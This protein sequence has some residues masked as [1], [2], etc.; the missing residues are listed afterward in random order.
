MIDYKNDYCIKILVKQWDLKFFRLFFKTV[1]LEN[2]T[3]C[4]VLGIL[5]LRRH[6]AFQVQIFLYCYSPEK[7][8]VGLLIFPSL[9][10]WHVTDM[11]E[12]ALR[13]TSF[14][15][16]ERWF[17]VYLFLLLSKEYLSSFFLFLHIFSKFPFLAIMKGS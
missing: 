10:A 17:F 7:N 13:G 12:I 1:K 11:E 6:S 5:D 3:K 8:K 9:G 14:G 15:L 2:K 4:L 16:R